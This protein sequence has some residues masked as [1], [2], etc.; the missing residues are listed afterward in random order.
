MKPNFLVP[1]GSFYL[2]M[3]ALVWASPVKAQG[4]CYMVKPSG[5]VVNLVDICGVSSQPNELQPQSDLPAESLSE[6][7]IESEAPPRRRSRVIVVEQDAADN[8]AEDA[9]TGEDTGSEPSTTESSPTE[10]ETSPAENS[11]PTV[12]DV[13]E[14]ILD[15][16]DG[17][18]AIE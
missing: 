10:T 18:D 2:V 11:G 1:V 16:L 8:T 9:T 17:Q 14:E 6:E 4:I 13:R 5:Q 15:S 12:P 7:A 3:S